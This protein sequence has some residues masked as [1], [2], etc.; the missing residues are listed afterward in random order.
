MALGYKFKEIQ[1]AVDH[2]KPQIKKEMDTE[3][4]VKLVLA[5]I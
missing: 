3:A 2:I 4:I 5:S 1:N